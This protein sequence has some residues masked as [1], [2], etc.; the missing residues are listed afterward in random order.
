MVKV[1]KENINKR[2]DVN[3]TLIH[4]NNKFYIVSDN[5]EEVL[6]FLS[7]CNGSII[8]WAE[9][10]SAISKEDAINNIKQCIFR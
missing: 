7:D 1:I 5:G 6:I 4:Y 3:Q 9:V 8:D 10:G 2:P